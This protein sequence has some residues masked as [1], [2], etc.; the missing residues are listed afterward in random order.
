MGFWEQFFLFVPPIAL[1]I[2]GAVF[3]ALTRSNSGKE[4]GV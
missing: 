4:G 3:F 2:V 1:V